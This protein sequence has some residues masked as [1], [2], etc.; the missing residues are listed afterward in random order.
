M[1]YLLKVLIIVFSVLSV[2]FVAG[3]Q[4]PPLAATEALQRMQIASKG[5]MRSSISPVTGLVNFVS[6]DSSPTIRLPSVAQANAETIAVSFL[7]TF[8]G[9]FGLSRSRNLRVMKVISRDEVGME[10]VRL[11]QTYEGVPITGAEFTVHVRNNGVKSVLAKGLPI[12]ES[13]DIN[14]TVSIS[15][16]QA[17][18]RQLLQKHHNSR[19]AEL[20]APRLELLNRGL[21]EGGFHVTRLAWF[22]EA[23]K[24]YLREFIWVD[25]NSGAILLNFSQL[26]DARNRTVYDGQSTATLP[27]SVICRSEGGAVSGD[28]DCDRA[29]D[30]SG[31]TYNYFFKIHGLDSY[32]DAGAELVS[33]IN[34]CR[35]GSPCPYPNAFWNGSQVVYGSGYAAADDVVAHELTHAVIDHSA[36]L[37]YYMQSG[38]L[39]ESYSD[40][41]GEAVD[42]TNGAGNDAAGLRWSMGE[43]IHAIRDM[44]YPHRFGD[45]GKLSDTEFVCQDPGD[46]QGGVHTNSGVPNRA[47]SLMVDGGTFNEET[48]VGMGLTKAAK[49]QYRALTQYLT[50]GSDFLDNYHA[51]QQSCSDLIGTAGI[52]AGNC[53]EVS[54]A[55]EAV[56]MNDPWPCLPAQVAGL[57]PANQLVSNTF[58]DDL[59]VTNSGNWSSSINVGTNHWSYPVALGSS[60]ATSG[61]QNLLGEG[62]SI[63][64]P[65][66]SSISLSAGVTI[67]ANAFLHFNHAYGFENN[68]TIEFSDGGVIEYSANAGP[69]V[70]AGSLITAGA[71]YGGVLASNNPLGGRPAFV[72]DSFGYTSS[73][74]DLESLAGQ[75]V[76][77]RFRM[78]TDQHIDDYGWFIDDVRIYTCGATVIPPLGDD[79][80]LCFPITVSNGKVAMICL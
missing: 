22:I 5:T 75:S 7:N 74:L 14:P 52:T 4:T 36:N 59:E 41:F 12:T 44:A 48:V 19:D 69:W 21:L 24:K 71:A 10:H 50:S 35:S 51:L 62:D 6:I 37:F 28:P 33:T 26:T 8:A 11:Q 9:A 58:F 34:H 79:D 80:E 27:G 70:D 55:I 42:L 49:I 60:F 53:R 73:K 1:S 63:G 67:P 13:I 39:N 54:R 61:V 46:D 20:S 3:A 17:A 66:D 38:A 78:G 31:D 30:Y 47:F 56:E 25:A 64:N 16:A 18:A 76:R 65:A 57:C 29:Y 43:D 2:P 40:I 23:S 32:D 45:P 77:F 15:Q 72:G 68:A